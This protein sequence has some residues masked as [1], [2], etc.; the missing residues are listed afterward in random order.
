MR[1]KEAIRRADEL[2][3]NTLDEARKA[4]WVYE[5]EGQ[6]AETRRAPPPARTWP[7]DM[8]L[9]MPPPYDTVYELYLCAM[10]DFANEETDLY[11]DDMALFNQRYAEA[12]AFWRRTHRLPPSGGFQ[13]V[14]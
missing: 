3:P 12:I 7:A 10:I 9:A 8:A 13:G 6:L 14:F 4:A 5:L 1:L 2:R 11:A